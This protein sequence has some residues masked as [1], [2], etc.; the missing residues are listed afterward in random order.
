[1]TYTDA[2]VH[3]AA[4]HCLAYPDES[5]HAL[6]PLVRAALRDERG[7]AAEALRGFLDHV[8][9]ADPGV[10]AAHYVQ[11]FD[12]DRN[13][14]H[15][16][17]WTDGDTRR[18]GQALVRFLEVY[19]AHG[20]E[21]AAGGELPDHL[22][23]VLEFTAQT[24]AV[25]LLHEHRPAL[26]LLRISLA[27]AD[28]GYAGVLEAVCATLPGPSPRDRA[29]ARALARSGPPREDVGLEPYG[30]LATLPLLTVPGAGGR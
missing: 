28:T 29:A 11:V 25:E 15:L 5:F 23:V 9:G 19:R 18:R 7:P 17:W 6:T 1:V 22:P 20:L 26:E 12:F 24:G 13:S 27:E 14:L 10:L 4:A 30:H 8:A 3:Q 16:S 2:V 21:F